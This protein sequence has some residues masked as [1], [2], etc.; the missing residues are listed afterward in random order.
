M[1]FF[2]EESV[3]FKMRKFSL[4]FTVLR[5]LKEDHGQRLR[6]GWASYNRAQ[7]RTSPNSPHIL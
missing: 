1:I 3:N 2:T 7:A 5:R 6:A 4:L